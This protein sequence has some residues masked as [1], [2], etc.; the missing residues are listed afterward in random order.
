MKISKA[1]GIDLGT[2]R[3]LIGIM[4]NEDKNILLW[5]NENGN[6]T[7]SFCCSVGQ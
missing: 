3:S 7:D 6:A 2:T 1:F 4:D 5:R